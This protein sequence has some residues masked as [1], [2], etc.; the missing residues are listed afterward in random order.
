MIDNPLNRI[1]AVRRGSQ[2][3]QSKLTEDDVAAIR[4]LVE[5]RNALIA[6]ARTLRNTDIARKFGV[7]VSSI[8]K[9]ATGETWGHVT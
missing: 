9:V 1:S 5:Y 3:H 8:N 4:A 7:C 2:C 6:E